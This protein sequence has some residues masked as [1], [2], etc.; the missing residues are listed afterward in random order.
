MEAIINSLSQAA[1]E[2]DSWASETVK[3]VLTKSPTSLKVALKQLQEGAGKSLEDCLRMELSLCLN[4]LNTH[5]F[6]EGVRAVVVD[7]D[8]DPKWNPSV[9]VELDE[10]Y[11]A[12]FFQYQWKGSP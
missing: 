4:I 7:K 10:E 1:E 6:Y 9:I 11:V 5:D 8:R 12:S 2:G 3:T